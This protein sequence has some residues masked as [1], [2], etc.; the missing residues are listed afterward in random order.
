MW[1]SG[2]GKLRDDE[3]EARSLVSADVSSAAMER[4]R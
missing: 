2:L 1:T 3:K 4:F